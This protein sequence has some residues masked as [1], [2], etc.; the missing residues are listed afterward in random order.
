[1]V[2]D[3]AGPGVTLARQV[4]HPVGGIAD[5]LG[6]GYSAEALEID[7]ILQQWVE[8]RRDEQVEV[9]DGGQPPQGR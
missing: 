9:G 8:G 5:D 2:K 3:R 4:K 1:V 6:G 7:R